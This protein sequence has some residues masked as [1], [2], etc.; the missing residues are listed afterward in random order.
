MRQP[1][2]RARDQAAWHSGADLS[3]EFPQHDLGHVPWIGYRPG[4]LNIALG[5]LAGRRM[6]AHGRQQRPGRYLARCHQL[7]D[8]KNPDL[9]R[10]LGGVGVGDYRVGGAEV[11]AD[12]VARQLLDDDRSPLW[13][14]I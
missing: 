9:R 3:G 5:E 4:E 14:R 13:E 11:D 10:R 6:I 1:T 12:Q 8:R 2:L 7:L